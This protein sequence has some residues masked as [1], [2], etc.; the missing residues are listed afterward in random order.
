MYINEFK[1][2]QDVSQGHYRN[3]FDKKSMR[4]KRT[5]E[6][7]EIGRINEGIIKIR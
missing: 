2:R 1:F 5:L 7:K 6:Q 4:K 3:I